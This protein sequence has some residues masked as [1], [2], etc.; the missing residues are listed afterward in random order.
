MV[1]SI[2]NVAQIQALPVSSAQLQ[3]VTREDPLLSRVYQYTQSEWPEQVLDD[4][5]PYWHRRWDLTIEAGCV[6]WGTRV[7]VLVKLHQCA[8]EM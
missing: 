4:L 2:F 8:L 6:L 1:S 5:K 3:R 7:L